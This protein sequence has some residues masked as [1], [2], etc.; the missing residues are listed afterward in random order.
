MAVETRGGFPNEEG[1]LFLFL[2]KFHKCVENL[3][4]S[5]QREFMSTETGWGE[6]NRPQQG[7]DGQEG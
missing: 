5:K 1:F 2:L 7:K 6:C 4:H 3:Q